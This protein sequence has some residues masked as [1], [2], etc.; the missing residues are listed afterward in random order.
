VVCGSEPVAELAATLSG[1]P[2]LWLTSRS[3]LEAL[4]SMLASALVRIKAE[5]L[6]G[7]AAVN[8]QTLIAALP[9]AAFV[10]DDR[11]KVTIWNE[12]AERVF[13]WSGLDVLG[14]T[15]PFIP[16]GDGDRFLGLVSEATGASGSPGFES[17][18]LFREGGGR[19]ISFRATPIRDL[20]GDG[21]SYLVVAAAGEFGVPATGDPG[22]D[23][24]KPSSADP[25]SGPAL[26]SEVA[27]PQLREGAQVLG[28][29]LQRLSRSLG[30]GE[31]GDEGPVPADPGT[32]ADPASAKMSISWTDNGELD[33]RL[34]L[35]A[36]GP[37][38]PGEAVPVRALVI[39]SDQENGGRLGRILEDL[40]YPAVVCASVPDALELLRTRGNGDGLL[41]VAIVDMVMPGGPDAVQAAK[42]LTTADPG[43]RVVV[44]SDH[45]IAGHKAHGFAAALGRPYT[46][47]NVRSALVEA[48]VVRRDGNYA[49]AATKGD[50]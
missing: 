39:Q 50:A 44:S 12:Q 21:S 6:R 5:R 36:A 25:P 24:R 49:P 42:L 9:L 17:R 37:E 22:S 13:G 11:G 29:F 7:D 48:L 33:V 20:L 14:Q 43:L 27:G 32:Y 34:R 30:A 31:G 15:P 41:E 46:D 38:T 19:D 28:R 2:H 8:A 10:L 4:A 35:P 40:G 18:C 1:D 47:E 16:E 3:R 26:T 23:A 45:G